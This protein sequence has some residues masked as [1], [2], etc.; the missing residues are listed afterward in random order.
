[1]KLPTAYSR[2]LREPTPVRRLFVWRNSF[3]FQ[4]SL[5]VAALLLPLDRRTGQKGKANN[6]LRSSSEAH[7]KRK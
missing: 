4:F 1:M 2:C 7:K 5:N 3:E 6:R